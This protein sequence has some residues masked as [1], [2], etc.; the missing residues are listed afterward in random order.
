[1]AEGHIAKASLIQ[2]LVCYAT[3]IHLLSLLVR[4]NTA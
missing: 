1:M 3:G 2:G 4:L